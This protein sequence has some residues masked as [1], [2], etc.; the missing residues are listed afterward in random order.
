MEEA[1][2]HP[3]P[4]IRTG[5][6]II[7]GAG[8][9]WMLGLL[10]PNLRHILAGAGFAVGVIVGMF[11]QAPH[12]EP[13]WLQV[14][15]L[16]GAI[17]LEAALIVYVLNKVADERDRILWI[18]FC[19]GLHFVPMGLSF[20]PVVA[21][22]GLINMAGAWWALRIAR[23]APVEVVGAVDFATKIAV[24]ALMVFA[25]PRWTFGL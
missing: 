3:Y 6:A 12:G 15:A 21:A 1:A 9:G 2:A 20:G 8:L 13:T 17:A 23:D 25:A 18:L 4:M 5:G 14:G 10:A 7:L 11:L 16:V 19:V 24:G 22:L